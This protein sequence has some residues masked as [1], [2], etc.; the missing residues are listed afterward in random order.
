MRIILFTIIVFISQVTS[1]ISQT[2]TLNEVLQLAVENS[3]NL[4][5]ISLQTQQTEL[6]NS[7]FNSGQ[8]PE[9]QLLLNTNGSVNNTNQLF[10]DGRELNRTGANASNT[11]A[12]VQVV[13]N[14]FDGFGMFHRKNILE[15]TVLE[16]NERTNQQELSVKLLAMQAYFDVL[17]TNEQIPILKENISIS[18]ER[19]DL[20]SYQK[21]IGLAS[22]YDVLLSSQ[23]VVDDSISYLQQLNLLYIQQKQLSRLIGKSLGTLQ[24]E[25]PMKQNTTLNAESVI[26]DYFQKNPFYK[27]AIQRMETARLRKKSLQSTQLPNIDFVSTVNLNRSASEAGFLAQNITTQVQYGLQLT[28]PLSQVLDLSSNV[29]NSQIDISI[30]ELSLKRLENDVRY[31]LERRVEQIQRLQA[32]VEMNTKNVELSN[33]IQTIDNSKLELGQISGNDYRIL[34][35]DGLRRKRTL[36][37]SKLEEL[38]SSIE[39]ELLL[40][41]R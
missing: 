7:R 23:A 3:E 11:S 1:V 34:Q 25:Y 4:K 40:L 38:Q 19:Y 28:Y 8:L 6:R 33:K 36:V 17:T 22:E 24:L 27:E 26:N 12:A 32:L 31:D 2:L 37:A 13:W 29:E 16:M 18:K 35:L 20:I 41:Q 5:I 14:I 30:E 9:V 21:S 39:L 15:S 10:V